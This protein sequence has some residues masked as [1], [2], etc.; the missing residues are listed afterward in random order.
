[1]IIMKMQH[2]I[3]KKNRFISRNDDFEKA[4]SSAITEDEL[5]KRMYLR[6]ESWKWNEK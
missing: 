1:M 2:F 3:K 4:Y 5:K 6:I